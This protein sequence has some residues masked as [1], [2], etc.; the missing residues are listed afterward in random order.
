MTPQQISQVQSYLRKRFGTEAI[1]LK[2]RKVQDS[3]EVYL[4][5]EILG[6]LYIDDEDQADISYDLNVSILQ[7]DLD[8]A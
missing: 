5:D 2:L 1:E 7:Q 8:E 4:N 6:L 3:V